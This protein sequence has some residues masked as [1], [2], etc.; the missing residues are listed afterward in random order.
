MASSYA[1]AVVGAAASGKTAM[2]QR[3]FLGR[4][5]EMATRTIL[6]EEFIYRGSDRLGPFSFNIS[7]FSG[8]NAGFLRSN[9]LKTIQAILFVTSYES[10][11][12][13]GELE[14]WK[15]YISDHRGLTG[16]DAPVCFVA[17]NKSDLPESQREIV[18][19][20]IPEELRQ[21]DGTHFWAVSAKTGFNIAKMFHALFEEVHATR[22]ASKPQAAVRPPQSP[23]SKCSVC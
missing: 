22:R 13:I 14:A 11:D 12:P 23:S 10:S 6:A 2:L 5:T 18:D 17:I 16:P 20:T 1:L 19:Q 21:E 15:L 3:F 4:Y 9:Y 7:D 8:D